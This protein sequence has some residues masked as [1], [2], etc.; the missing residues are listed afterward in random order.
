M[1]NLQRHGFKVTAI[2]DKVPERCDPFKG[3]IEVK[4][5]PK[6]VAEN[7]DVVITGNV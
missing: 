2:L 7:V 3:Q 4:N 1:K 6:E 5:T